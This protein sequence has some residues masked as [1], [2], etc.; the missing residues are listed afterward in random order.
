[1]KNPRFAKSSQLY[2]PNITNSS[3]KL[4]PVGYEVPGERRKC[5]FPIIT[6]STRRSK[7]ACS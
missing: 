5:A 4:I 2:T 7:L 3:Q 1:M 6:E